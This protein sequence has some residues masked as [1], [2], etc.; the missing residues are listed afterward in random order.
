MSQVEE[1]SAVAEAAITLRRELDEDY[2]E[3]WKITWH[4]RRLLPDTSRE[5]LRQ[6]GLGVLSGLVASGAALGDLS[7]ETG[8]FE[9]RDPADALTEATRQWGE[10]DRDLTMGD[11]GW[12]AG[13]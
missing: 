5:T 12:L 13:T 1:L 3:V 9:P 8:S 4:L 6:L 7:D 11:I 10:L 2:V